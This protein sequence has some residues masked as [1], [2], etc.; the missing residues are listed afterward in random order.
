M[1]YDFINNFILVDFFEIPLEVFFPK[2]GIYRATL[3]LTASD[4]VRV[5][6]LEC[7]VST[8]NISSLTKEKLIEDKRERFFPDPTV[9][10]TEALERLE[11]K[12]ISLDQRVSN[13]QI[14][15]SNQMTKTLPVTLE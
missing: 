3:F 10:V 6:R 13:N 9:F 1:E 5:F 4:D 8:D 15:I 2:Q 11:Q 14:I 7:N 12:E